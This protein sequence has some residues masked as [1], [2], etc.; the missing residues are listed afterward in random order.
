MA[1]LQKIMEIHSFLTWMTT[2]KDISFHLVGMTAQSHIHRHFNN[3]LLIGDE[4]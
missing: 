3:P 4:L 1:T 2:Q